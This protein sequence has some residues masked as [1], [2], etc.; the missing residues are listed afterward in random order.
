MVVEWAEDLELKEQANMDCF[1][2]QDLIL[3]GMFVG[4]DVFAT[5]GNDK[6]VRVYDF[7]TG[8]HLYSL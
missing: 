1:Q 8:K 5:G 2:H 4:S 7:E 3:C 6:M